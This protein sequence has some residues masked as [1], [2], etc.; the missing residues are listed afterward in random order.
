MS[1]PGW[2]LWPR[3][4]KGL[5]TIPPQRPGERDRDRRAAPG[6][7]P[8]AWRGRRGRRA[9][10]PRSAGTAG[11][12]GRCG[13]RRRR[14]TI[15]TGSRAGRAGTGAPRRPS[16]GSPFRSSLLPRRCGPKRPSARQARVRPDDAVGREPVAA[17]EP[18]DRPLGRGAAEPVDR[19][20]V[21]PALVE[22]D[23][24]RSHALGSPA[25]RAEA[26]AIS[27]TSSRRR[28]GS[29]PEPRSGRVQ[30][31]APGLLPLGRLVGEHA[32]LPRPGDRLDARVD[33]ERAQRRRNVVAHRLRADPE[34]LRHL[35]GG[36][37]AREQVEHLVL[38]RLSAPGAAASPGRRAGA[39]RTSRPPRRPPAPA[40]S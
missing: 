40:P 39:R 13:R 35:L 1:T 4:P 29:R 21:D 33:P 20:L 7:A 36:R 38:A 30:A 19:A 24:E 14:R 26:A 23:L 11:R 9:R 25:E 32:E 6:A 16:P 2:K 34:H 27:A 12:R 18:E 15:P 8:R 31:P 28:G 3:G 22:R 37:P 10:A 5:V 17:L